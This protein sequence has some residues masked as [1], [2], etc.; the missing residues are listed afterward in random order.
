MGKVGALVA[1]GYT[2]EDV[3]PSIDNPHT[4]EVKNAAIA[5]EKITGQIVLI[6]HFGNCLT[7]IPGNMAAEFGLDLGDEVILTTPGGKIEAMFGRTYGDIPS[8]KPVVFINSLDLIELAINMGNF[9]GVHNIS[10]GRKI[11]IEIKK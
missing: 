8:G 7:N 11:E 6:D 3:G 9:A 2:P 5:G 1:S 4:F 10:T